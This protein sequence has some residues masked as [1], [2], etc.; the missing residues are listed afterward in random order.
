VGANLV[1]RLLADG[2]RVTALVRPGGDPWRLVGLG[3]DVVEADVRESVP[4]GFGLVY[5]LASHGQYSWQADET[6]I[7]ETT[8]LGT[9]N[10]LRAG[11]RVVVAGSSSEYGLKDH[12]PSEDELPAPNSAYAAAK[13]EATA[14]AVE[15][16]AVVL[17]LYSAY[18]PWEEPDR[19]VPTLL[20]RALEGELPPLVSPR[21]A[22]DFVHVDDVCEAFVTAARDAPAGRVYNVGSG[23]QTTIAEIVDVVRRLAGVETEPDWGSMPDRGWDTETWVANPERIREELGWEA[24]IVLEEG[25]DRT[26]AW[27][28][29]EAPRERYGLPG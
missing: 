1:R 6:A 17:R 7:G 20:G 22:R 8:V 16:G 10:A 25:L 24:R 23:R 13:A 27:L 28:R 19:L 5:H 26:L 11:A 15:Q 9:R 18:G 4:D 21:I 3:V 2:A 14:L 12:A 29:R